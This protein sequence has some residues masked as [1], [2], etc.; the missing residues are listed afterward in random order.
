MNAE[1]F[2]AQKMH[3]FQNIYSTVSYLSIG[4]SRAFALWLDLICIF[5]IAAVSL[6]FPLFQN[7]IK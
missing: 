5:L 2:M 4:T 3:I 6:Y 7:G 1:S